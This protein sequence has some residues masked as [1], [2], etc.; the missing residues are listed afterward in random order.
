VTWKD[1]VHHPGRNFFDQAPRVYSHH[2]ERAL[3]NV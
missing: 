1:R 3:L 2:P